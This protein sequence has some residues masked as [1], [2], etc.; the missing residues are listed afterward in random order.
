MGFFQLNWVQFSQEIIS[1]L[2]SSEV[3]GERVN[4]LLEILTIVLVKTNGNNSQLE[5]SHT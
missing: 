5:R 4:S 2:I 3:T 1:E